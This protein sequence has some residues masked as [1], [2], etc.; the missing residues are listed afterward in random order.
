MSNW[1]IICKNDCVYCDMVIELFD[2]NF[3]DYEKK[4]IHQMSDNFVKPANAKYYP[5]IFLDGDYFGGYSELKKYFQ[6]KMI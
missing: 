5:F 1:L 3:I 4:Y 2:N 6:K